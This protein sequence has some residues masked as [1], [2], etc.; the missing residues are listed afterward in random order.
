MVCIK[1]QGVLLHTERHLWEMLLRH[2]R[3]QHSQT[4]RYYEASF[5]DSGHRTECLQLIVF[6]E[7]PSDVTTGN[8]VCSHLCRLLRR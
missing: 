1:G 3:C 2:G 7:E 6:I 4:S 8:V 5:C